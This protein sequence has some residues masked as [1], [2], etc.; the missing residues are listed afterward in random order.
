MDNNMRQDVYPDRTGK[1]C[2]LVASVGLSKWMDLARVER[3]EVRSIRLGFMCARWAK[4]GW[5]YGIC[6]SGARDANLKMEHLV[7]GYTRLV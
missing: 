1:W 2:G 7:K 6:T 3:C 5:V 4:R